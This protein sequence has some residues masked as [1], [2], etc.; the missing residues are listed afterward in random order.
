MSAEVLP[1]FGDD[2]PQFV[3]P[4][5]TYA[6]VLHGRKVPMLSAHPLSGGRVLLCLDDRFSVEVSVQDAER[7]VP[8]VAHTIAVGMGYS[9]F[10]EPGQQPAPRQVMPRMHSL[11]DLP[12]S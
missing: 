11:T 4:I 8:F 9:S 2:G 6:V 5:E 3:G 7:I 12:T 10:P 1:S